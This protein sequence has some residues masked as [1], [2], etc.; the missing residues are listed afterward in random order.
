MLRPLAITPQ[1][2]PG[3]EAAELRRKG[4]QHSR[5]SCGAPEV[6]IPERKVL[7][8][9]N[10]DPRQRKSFQLVYRPQMSM[11]D[12]GEKLWMDDQHLTRCT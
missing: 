11:W 12:Q 5:P 8:L 10:S 2:D 1:S 9:K 3:E 6:W 7:F 4:W